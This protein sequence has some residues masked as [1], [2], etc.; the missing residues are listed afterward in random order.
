MGTEDPRRA[1]LA[2]ALAAAF[3]LVPAAVMTPMAAGDS[4]EYYLTAES[5]LNHGTP[6]LRGADVSIMASR[7]ARNPV[8]GAFRTLTAYRTGRN[9][10][11]YAQHFWA[12]P[13]VTLPVRALLRRL[14]VNEYKAFAITNALLLAAAVWLWLARA[15]YPFPWRA[16]G[17]ALLVVS[18]IGWFVHW[19]HPEVYSAALVTAALVCWRWGRLVT[20]T[21]LAALGALQNPPLLILTGLLWLRAVTERGPRRDR[22][23]ALAS[24][25]A[26]P[27]VVPY[28]FNLWAFGTPSL[29]ADENVHVSLIRPGRF[30]ELLYDLN[31]GLIAYVPLTLMLAVVAS[32]VALA[33]PCLRGM[34]AAAWLA[35]VAMASVCSAMHDW[36][37]GTS[38]PS[39]YAVWLFPLLVVLVCEI[40][41]RVGGRW[42]LAAAAAALAAQ[43]A[44]FVARRGFAARED[45]VQH[46]WLARFVLARWPA[47]Y[48]PTPEIFIE[49]TSHHD[50][51]EDEMV[52]PYVYTAGGRCRKAYAQKRH[53][54]ALLEQC[55]TEPPAFT[56]FRAE[57]QERSGGRK[58][59]TYVNY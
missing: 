17:A 2:A 18:P 46:S 59:W 3:L 26:L 57:V 15:P 19:T 43:A 53:A 55:G 33:R 41:A 28:A 39:R 10:A 23:F 38:G 25:A 47:L 37:H 29:I 8:T 48:A 20:A 7:M 36:N 13:A 44:V 5:L 54:A 32:V 4:G 56:A 1:R 22:R 14:P 9:G 34:V 27:A 45:Y 11:Q 50:W 16:V 21:L 52:G 42:M 58:E 49:R 40:G 24:L 31:I 12:Y 35:L 30:L 6:E 51:A